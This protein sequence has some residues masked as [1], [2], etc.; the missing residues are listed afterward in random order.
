[1]RAIAEKAPGKKRLRNFL[2]VLIALISIGYAIALTGDLFIFILY[3]QLAF[4]FFAIFTIKTVFKDGIALVLFIGFAV[5]F[6]LQKAELS[7]ALG[8]LF[9]TIFFGRSLIKTQKRRRIFTLS[10]IM[11]VAAI[12]L[13]L[14]SL[15]YPRFHPLLDRSSKL[16]ALQSLPY[17]ASVTGE[18]NKTKEGVVEYDRALNADGLN[19]Y[20]SYDKPEA[21]LLDM[22]GKKLHDWR[23]RGSPPRWQFVTACDNGDLLVCVEDE[24]LMRV[25]WASHILWQK[26]MRIHHDIAVAENKDI[27]TLTSR[28]ELVFDHFLPIPIINDYIV[29]LSP[30]G[31]VRE[32]V[33]LFDLMKSQ[34]PPTHI[35]NIYSRMI[36]PREYLWRIIKQKRAHRLLLRRMTPFDV[37]HNN[38]VTLI[39]KNIK[40]LCKKG[41]VLVCANALDL[42]GVVDTENQKLGWT[43]G[44]GQLDKPHNPTFLENGHILIF[45]NGPTRA[46]SRIEE[47]DPLESRI[48][49]EYPS[50]RPAPFF[51]SWGGSAQRLPNGDTLV[52]E[53]SLGRVFEI[54]KDGDIVWDFFNPEREEDGNRATIYRMTRITDPHLQS[55]LMSNLKP[56]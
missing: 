44:P 2:T 22:S 8:I 47:L 55:I 37:F 13:L 11:A 18:K 31:V 53:T 48:V 26:N 49:W 21:Y 50:S 38:T 4:L 1:M 42:I 3:F 25:D 54:T 45:D 30:D 28:E 19:L 40:G 23:P 7:A 46:Y 10:S 36:Y 27:L 52:T 33:S 43:W 15:P 20:N 17:V 56:E 41:N 29:T 14:I 34:I 35:L 51:S 39:D 24:M 6:V 32:N 12:Y 5:L 16:E 9:L